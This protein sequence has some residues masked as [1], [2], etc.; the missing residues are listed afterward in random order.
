[1]CWY[2]VSLF[3]TI[4]DKALV[5]I[6]PKKFYYLTHTTMAWIKID[7]PENK[8]PRFFIGKKGIHLAFLSSY[9]L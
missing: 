7:F 2:L 4:G 6:Y 5:R 8:L 9:M 1:M 3:F